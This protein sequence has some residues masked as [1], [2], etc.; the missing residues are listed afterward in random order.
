MLRA[1]DMK[2]NKMNYEEMSMDE[3]FEEMFSLEDRINNFH[4]NSGCPWDE[5]GEEEE[6]LSLPELHRRF[7]SC[8]CELRLFYVDEEECV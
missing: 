6:E 1:K 5:D 7:N 8:S 4:K 3:L 2:G